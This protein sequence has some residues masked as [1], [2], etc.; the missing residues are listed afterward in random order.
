[1]SISTSPLQRTL[2]VAS[3]A[4]LVAGIGATVLPTVDARV[5][6]FYAQVF[7]RAVRRRDE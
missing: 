1:M 3:V 4:L 7:A 6:G 5:H 2:I